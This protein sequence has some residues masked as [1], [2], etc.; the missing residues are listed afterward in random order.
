ML[1]AGFFDEI[2]IQTANCMNVPN[3]LGIMLEKIRAFHK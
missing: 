2:F 1:R 3:E